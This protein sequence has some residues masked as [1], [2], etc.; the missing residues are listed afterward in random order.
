[1]LYEPASSHDYIPAQTQ[2]DFSQSDTY[3]RTLQAAIEQVMVVEKSV[4]PFSENLRVEDRALLQ[5]DDRE[6]VMSYVGKLKLPPETAYEQLDERL[7]SQQ[8]TALFRDN[9]SLNENT[10]HII[11]IISG[12][13]DTA[14]PSGIPWMNIILFLATIISVLITGTVI[15]IGEIGLG[16]EFQAA[17]LARNFWGEIWRGWPYALSIMLILVAHEG[18]HYLMM[19]RHRVNGSLPY[20]IPMPFISPFGTFGAAI[21]LRGPIR[22]R[23]QLL[24]IGASGPLAGLIVALPILFIGLATSP[25]IR[26]FGGLTEGNSILYALAKITI[27]G[28]FLPAG[29]EDVIVNQLAWAGWTGLFVTA[30]N[31]IPIGQLDG[32][33]VTYA[34]LG[35]WA[36]RLYYPL[37]GAIFVLILL[38]DDA[39]LL[40]FV[41]LF[42]VGRV[43]AVP[44]DNITKLDAKRKRIALVTLVVFILT[45]V[46]TPMSAAGDTGGIL[47]S[48]LLLTAS[49]IVGGQ[50]WR[51]SNL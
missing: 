2:D 10:P 8:L 42:L 16:D 43:Y 45:F 11:H 24:D 34:L 1:M 9:L 21:V 28:R 6:F 4:L 29:G 25:V 51:A 37:L 40:L 48:S 15:A 41:L 31:L 18:G 23:K 7:A 5:R 17:I 19:R 22:N 20:F 32:G 14:V 47:A 36:R 49:V 26:T 39:W 50:R 38:V 30:L 46:P 35:D 33:H 27:F 3:L 12:R 13:F 44:L